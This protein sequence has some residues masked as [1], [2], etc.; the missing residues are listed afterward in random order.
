MSLQEAY[1]DK[2]ITSPLCTRSTIVFRDIDT[3]VFIGSLQRV[4]VGRVTD[5]KSLGVRS[6]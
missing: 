1:G 6:V 4:A 3:L 2:K 5:K